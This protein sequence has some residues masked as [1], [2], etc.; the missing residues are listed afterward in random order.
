[1]HDFECK[2][3]IIDAEWTESSSKKSNGE[4]SDRYVIKRTLIDIRLLS[5][6]NKNLTR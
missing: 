1:M 4:I 3:I 2:L 6:V 5:I